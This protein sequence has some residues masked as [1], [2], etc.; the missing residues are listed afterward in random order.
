VRFLLSEPQEERLK[1]GGLV[2]LDQGHLHALA[3][4]DLRDPNTGRTRVRTV[5][6]NSEHYISTRQYMIRL[7][8][9][10]LT[11]PEMRAKL[12]EAANMTP[13]DFSKAFATVVGLTEQEAA[14]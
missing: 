13:G 5:D 4:G 11:D 6:I 12:A 3:F 1:P 9:R 7:E 10:N 8:A 2:C 14:G